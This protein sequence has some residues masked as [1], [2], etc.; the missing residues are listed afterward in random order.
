MKLTHKITVQSA[1][2]MVA[3]VMLY[4]QTYYW[5]E[6]HDAMSGYW[7]HYPT[8]IMVGAIGLAAVFGGYIGC[9]V[10]WISV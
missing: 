2:V 8:N 3:S 7:Y 9:V 4:A 5:M 10:M 6:V 1:V